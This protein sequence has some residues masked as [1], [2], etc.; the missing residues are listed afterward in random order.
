MPL[1]QSCREAAQR[2][3]ENM[4]TDIALVNVPACSS[5]TLRSDYDY[6]DAASFDPILWSYYKDNLQSWV[7]GAVLGGLAAF[8]FLFLFTWLLSLC[9]RRHYWKWELEVLPANWPAEGK[10]RS[11]SKCRSF[12]TLLIVVLWGGVVGLSA[13]GMVEGL[14]ESSS[15]LSEFWEVVIQGRNQVLNVTSAVDAML[16][17]LDTIS[18]GLGVLAGTGAGPDVTTATPA[19]PVQVGDDTVGAGPVF[20]RSVTTSAEPLLQQAAEVQR[21]VDEVVT[22]GRQ[23]LEQVEQDGLQGL[24]DFIKDGYDVSMKVEDTWRYVMLA[25]FFS[26][27]ILTATLAT[28]LVLHERAPRT[29]AFFTLTLWLATALLLFVGAGVLSAGYTVSGDMC[30]YGEQWTIRKAQR[31][32][33]QPDRAVLG[34]QYYFGGANLTAEDLALR[35]YGVDVDAVDGAANSAGPLLDYLASPEGQALTE[36]LPAAS[37]ARSWVEGLPTAIASASANL[38][39]FQAA[40]SRDAFAP[41]HDDAKEYV[42]C[43]L[44]D[45]LYGAWIAWTADGCA[46]LLLATLLTA[47]VMSLV[48]YG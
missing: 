25:V 22:Q 26:L 46:A 15:T 10:Q 20:M 11:R 35:V 2:L 36:Q 32:L 39:A 40:I 21:Q 18:Q 3:N 29:G 44:P 4:A 16:V 38:D 31:H 43:D 33:E 48:V 23:A 5:R 27:V 37:D 12:S 30:L 47:R 6:A 13:W 9:C 7:P 1:K 34:L 42:C 45:L 14:S 41:L 19:A 24:N 17:D 28:I 8:G